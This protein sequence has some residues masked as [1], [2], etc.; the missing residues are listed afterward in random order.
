MTV[1]LDQVIHTDYG[2]FDLG[3]GEFGFDGE[4]DR[5]FAGQLNGLVG[6][7]ST[8][9][10]YVHFARR[11]GGSAVRLELHAEEP[12]LN[13]WEDVVEV[14]STLRRGSLRWAGWAGEPC[15]ECDVPAGDYR[16]RVSARGRDAGRADEFADGVVD[17]YLIELWPSA[18]RDDEI[19]RVSSQDAAYWHDAWGN[20]R[21]R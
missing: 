7:A 5:F 1:L 21:E 17:F 9:T 20:R 19:V 3:E 16:V 14:S 4:A 10:V 2:Q 18:L 8:G 13:D 6:A 11:S 15:G 12:A